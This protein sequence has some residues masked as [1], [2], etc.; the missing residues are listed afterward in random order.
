MKNDTPAY[1]IALQY[2]DNVILTL[3]DGQ[4]ISINL[5]Y[6]DETVGAQLPELDIMLPRNMTANCFLEGLVPASPD[7]EHPNCLSVRQICIPI[8]KSA[9]RQISE[10][11]A[12]NDLVE[13]IQSCDPDDLAAIYSHLFGPVKVH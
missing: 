11:Q 2:E 10:R 4:E 8:E 3:P 12:T 9:V 6:N 13:Y 1:N 7:A 5:L